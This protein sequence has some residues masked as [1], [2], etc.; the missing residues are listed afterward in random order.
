MEANIDGRQRN[1]SLTD[2]FD[3]SGKPLRWPNAQKVLCLDFL[4]ALSS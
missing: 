2:D 3:L 1:S 4:A